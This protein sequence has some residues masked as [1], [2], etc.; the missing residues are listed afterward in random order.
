VILT[1]SRTP[2]GRFT[3]RLRPARPRRRL[4][5][6]LGDRIDAEP[7]A[8][9][10]APIALNVV[11]F[12][13]RAGDAVTR[14]IAVALQEAGEVAPSTTT[15]DGRLALR[16]AIVNRRTAERDIAALVDQAV[17]AGRRLSGATGGLKPRETAGT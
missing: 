6:A 15:I 1:R 9:R 10:L 7:V 8:E 12:R 3:T 17:A 11:C 2:C 13:Q 4:A 14:E 5:C 16:A